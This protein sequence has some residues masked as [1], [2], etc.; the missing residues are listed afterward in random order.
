MNAH[1]LERRTKPSQTR[2]N[3]TV[4]LILETAAELLETSGFEELTTNKICKA[5]GLTPP[6]LY[7]Y[8]PN[9]YAVVCELAKQLM[10]LQ[11]DSIS[12]N[13]K[14]IVK[15]GLDVDLTA[16]ILSGLVD[17]TRE[18][19]GGVAVLKTLYATPQL[20]Q[21]R[22]SSHEE[23]TGQLTDALLQLNLGLAQAELHRRVRLMIEVGNSVV[24]MIVENEGMD[25]AAMIRDTAEMMHFLLTK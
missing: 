12:Q 24:E 14:T 17:I 15:N 20:A 11:D 2:A 1:H 4:H 10:Q 21:V 8:F 7:R 25:E 6:A 23:V 9:K 18:F 3:K 16:S 5:A 19:P 13:A 22:L